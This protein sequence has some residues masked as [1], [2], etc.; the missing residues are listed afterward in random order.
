[1]KRVFAILLSLA[2]MLGC[3][4]CF[5]EAEAPA[6]TVL[7]T[8][9][10]NGAF[11]LQCGIPEGY[12][13]TTLVSNRDQ[14]IAT[15]SA[16]D[17]TKP[18]MVLSVAFDELY[19]DVDRMNDLDEEALAVLEKTFTDNDPTVDISY[20]DT[21]LGTRLLIARQANDYYNYID[22]MSVY[23][24]YFVEFILV[25]GPDAAERTLTDEQLR[26]CID[27]LTDLD[28]IPVEPS[29]ELQAELAEKTYPARISDYNPDANT[30][31]ITVMHGFLLDPAE[32][33]ALQVGSTL[34]LGSQ[35]ITVETLEKTEDGDII[36][37]DE[38]SLR[39]YGEN[40]HAYIYEQEYT[41][42]LTSITAEL[43]D[44]LT[45]LDEVD[46]ATGE[47]AE[48]A[49]ERSLDE[50]KAL[51]TGSEDS[52]DPGFAS[53]NVLVTFNAEGQPILVQRYYAPWQ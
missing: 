24:G 25:P 21:G 18:V 50:F 27:F 20:G 42:E 8:I 49:V 14:L 3:G 28:F 32:I 41:E 10:I 16:D 23:K 1:M 30:V 53:D 13:V 19:A 46:P 7:G 6:K 40:Y 34:M 2:L 9:E 44:G 17:R 33:E 37:N 12:S 11:S 38:I 31:E 51:L 35:A 47:M 15:L 5:A 39:L 43:P 48:T 26:I 52:M 29:P 36:V 4:A 22:F 45:L